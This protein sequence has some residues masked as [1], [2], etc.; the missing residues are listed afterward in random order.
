MLWLGDLHGPGKVPVGGTWTWTRTSTRTSN[1]SCGSREVRPKKQ[2]RLYIPYRAPNAPSPQVRLDRLDPPGSHPWPIEPKRMWARSPIGILVPSCT[3]LLEIR[4]ETP[5]TK[6]R[7][8]VYRIHNPSFATSPRLLAR[9]SSWVA[10]P[11]SPVDLRFWTLDVGFSGGLVPFL[12]P[13]VDAFQAPFFGGP[14]TLRPWFL[15]WFVS[16]L[17]YGILVGLASDRRIIQIN[18]PK[19]SLDPGNQVLERS[20]LALFRSGRLAVSPHMLKT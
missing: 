11:S 18:F 1:R 3:H 20:T 17:S 13:Q 19:H 2:V 5:G 6:D 8:I 16:F 12:S 4:T 14:C 9:P 7:S 15:R 10:S